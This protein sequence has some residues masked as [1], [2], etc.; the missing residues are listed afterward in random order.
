[1]PSGSLVSSDTKKHMV[2]N[3]STVAV[4]PI[5]SDVHLSYFTEELCAAINSIGVCVF[6][7][8]GGGVQSC[9]RLD[10][11]YC[12]M[13]TLLYHSSLSESDQFFN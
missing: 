2:S 11:A 13:Y 12:L 9:S 4:V 3:L 10:T 8:G 6:R 7:G 1:M 5:T